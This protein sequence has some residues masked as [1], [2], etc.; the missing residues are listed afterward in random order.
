M[1]IQ[2]IGFVGLGNMGLPMASR[3]VR[4]GFSVLAFDTDPKRLAEF[5]QATG[6]KTGQDLREI[7]ASA[8]AVITML[9]NSQIVNHVVDGED[10]LRSGFKQGGIL[11]E[12]SSGAPGMTKLLANSLGK[13][14]VDVADAPVS[15]GVAK[16]KTGELS[17]M[18]GTND[19]IAERIKPVLQAMGTSILRTGDIGSAHA[20]KALN[21]LVSAGGFLIGIEALLIGKEFGLNPDSMVDILNAS[22][23]M[24][25]STQRKFKQ[26]VL[27]RA[28]NSGFGLDLMIKDV[29][30]ALDLGKQV[31]ANTPFAS[32][33]RELS[34]S[35]S[36]LLGPGQDHTA[37]ALF[38]EKLAGVTLAE[39]AD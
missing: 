5:S 3:L 8:D 29:S 39:T 26:F 38:A 11:I 14:G 20:M 15:G 10:G 35:A 24:N 33:L 34:A 27:S 19:K 36:A 30:I 4:A 1:S 28:F 31:G 6:S 7:A 13:L 12:M 17:I 37:L 9:P 21:N 25:N 16:A 32:L 23:G 2:R 22:T 18:L